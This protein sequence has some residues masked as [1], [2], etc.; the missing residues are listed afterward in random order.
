[1][2]QFWKPA[3]AGALLVVVFS[4]VGTQGQ[5]RRS[6]GCFSRTTGQ[7]VPCTNPVRPPGPP[8]PPQPSPEE[9]ARAKDE[10]D[11]REASDDAWD[12]GV[13]AYKQGDFDNAVR[14]FQQ[15]LRYDRDRPEYNGD[16][17]DLLQNLQAA[18]MM[19]AKAKQPPAPPPPAAPTPAPA[20]A[21][22][23]PPPV[24]T[25]VYSGNA[26]VGG[27]SWI[28]GFNVQNP[29]PTL[30]AKSHEMLKSQ[31]Q[32]AGIPYSA[33]IDFKR[34]NFVIGIG[35]STSIF[36][37]LKNRVLFDEFSQGKFS[38]E[39]QSLYNSLKGREFTEMAC[40]S[41][42]AMV[43]LVALVNRDVKV[44]RVALYG[45]QLTRQSLQ[46]WQELIRSGLVE[47]VHVYVNQN[48]PVPPFSIS[49]GDLFQ[50]RTFNDALLKLST[51]KQIISSQAADLTVHTFACGRGLPT[52]TC[53]DMA[54]YKSERG[55]ISSPSGGTVP[56]TSL[57]GK[58]SLREPPPPC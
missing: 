30:V 28:A 17:P 6:L 15:A 5:G 11:L 52:L 20:P 51:L 46:M 29:D 53:H 12:K 7:P 42:G 2:K 1:M 43:C 14:W 31:M 47:S 16:D 27:T 25:Y 22:P 24:K 26:F 45:P 19:V 4:C 18:Q 48:D 44:K 54:R 8:P 58:G 23:P 13:A 35:N 39:R 49:F 33:G 9:I 21:P 10:K 41:N 55:C 38:A 32:L 57:P 40:H 36:S 3:A 37:D 56:G 50:N 34:Y